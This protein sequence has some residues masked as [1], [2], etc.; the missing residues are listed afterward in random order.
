[1]RTTGGLAIWRGGEYMLSFL[2]ANQ[3]WFQQ[4]N[5]ADQ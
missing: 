4:T 3:L 5:I 1:M 2:F